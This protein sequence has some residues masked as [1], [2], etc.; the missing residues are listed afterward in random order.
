ML[1]LGAVASESGS[2]AEIGKAGR[3]ASLDQ[4]AFAS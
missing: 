3:A 2:L 1:L 4:I